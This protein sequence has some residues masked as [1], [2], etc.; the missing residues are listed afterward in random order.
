[1]QIALNEQ[2]A[3][4]VT[5]AS[6]FVLSENESVKGHGNTIYNCLKFGGLDSNHVVVTAANGHAFYTA[7]ATA[8]V[9]E[10]GEFVM[11]ASTLRGALERFSNGNLDVTDN[12][13]HIKEG[14]GKL[15]FT[16]DVSG[17]FPS[18]PAFEEDSGKLTVKTD[19]FLR[20]LNTVFYAAMKDS[21]RPILESVRV[22]VQNEKIRFDAV[23]GFIAARF[24]AAIDQDATVNSFTEAILPAWI[25]RQLLG[26]RQIRNS[27]TISVIKAKKAV[28]IKCGDI[29]M[30]SNELAGDFMDMEKIFRIS[31]LTLICDMAAVSEIMKKVDIVAATASYE[32]TKTPVVLDFDPDDGRLNIRIKSS[33]S[34]L[35]DS[36]E[37][38]AKGELK[39]IHMGFNPSLL[40][41]ALGQVDTGKV[42]FNIGGNLSPMIILPQYDKDMFSAIHLVLPV[43]LKEEQPSTAEEIK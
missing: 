11:P 29:I 17:T 28:V 33:T 1:M 36:V 21:T 26:D 2:V 19:T 3:F 24:Q 32:K 9:P 7:R 23:N 43:R 31:D 13:V 12:V 4:V 39:A 30:L 41:Q 14:R 37:C 25:V 38:D 35:E 16:V 6:K 40:K 18:I 22:S 5:E 10:I 42:G 8:I 15:N 27:V 20:G 34:V